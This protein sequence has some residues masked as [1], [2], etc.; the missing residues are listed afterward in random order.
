[1]GQMA[2][3]ST[4]KQTPK[5][6]LEMAAFQHP[7]YQHLF[8]V[9][10]RACMGVRFECIFVDYG[11]VF[12]N[13]AWDLFSTLSLFH[14]HFKT[15][16]FVMCSDTNL[17]RAERDF[18]DI[19]NLF[20]KR[21][22][23]PL[24]IKD[25]KMCDASYFHAY[26]NSTKKPTFK[27]PFASLCD[28]QQV[29]VKKAL[30]I[31]ITGKRWLCA[32][33]QMTNFWCAGSV[34]AEQ[35]VDVCKYLMDT[36]YDK[37]VLQKLLLE[38][39]TSAKDAYAYESGA[40]KPL[41]PIELKNKMCQRPTC[42]KSAITVGSQQWSMFQPVAILPKLT[43]DE[44]FATGRWCPGE[45]VSITHSNILH[46]RYWATRTQCAIKCCRGNEEFLRP[47]SGK[48]K[49]PRRDEWRAGSKVQC[50]HQKRWCDAEVM[51]VW[52]VPTSYSHEFKIKV[53]VEHDD[54]LRRRSFERSSSRVRPCYEWE[55]FEAMAPVTRRKRASTGNLMV[56]A[57]VETV[58][59]AMEEASKTNAA[60]EAEEEFKSADGGDQ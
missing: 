19:R 6:P 59:E 8:T 56:D 18:N 26:N 54:E 37:P 45:I 53:S 34:N 13:W 21:S 23:H 31:D 50:F 11:V 32:H 28:E 55:S 43:D 12:S 36:L 46:V 52:P 41:Q 7:V 58:F 27:W 29:D 60:D 47:M 5:M 30:I 1:M 40:R 35:L 38:T 49:V 16:I 3:M 57:V 4:K 9:E 44:P 42:T 20:K 51:R 14:E 25:F 33:R 48:C 39:L 24:C 10:Q 15:K 2:Q 17:E 22:S